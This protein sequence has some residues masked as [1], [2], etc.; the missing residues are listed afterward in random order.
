M[1]TFE[2]KAC[3]FIR[4]NLLPHQIVVE[5]QFFLLTPA[6]IGEQNKV[7][8]DIGLSFFVLA[9]CRDNNRIVTRATVEYVIVCLAVDCYTV[10]ANI[11]GIARA[12]V[13]IKKCSA[14][15]I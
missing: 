15:R 14:T 10:V 7:E 5:A 8:V 2:L 6:K 12:Y 4:Q 1:I 13:I 11:I 9:D 3:R